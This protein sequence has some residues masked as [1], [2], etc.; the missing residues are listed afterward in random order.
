MVN[1]QAKEAMDNKV[2]DK[3]NFDLLFR[4]QGYDPLLTRRDHPYSNT[5]RGGAAVRSK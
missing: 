2:K 4:H 5:V 3:N 1:P